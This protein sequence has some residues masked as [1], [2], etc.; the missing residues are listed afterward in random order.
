[1][2][3]PCRRCVELRRRVEIRGPG[4][5]TRVLRVVHAHLADGSL[6]AVNAADVADLPPEGPWPDVIGSWF[7]CT[8]CDRRFEIAAET[9]HGGGG[10]WRPA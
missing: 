10:R 4:E 6:A 5:L 8:S 2:I 9:Y 7:R 3:L 1:M